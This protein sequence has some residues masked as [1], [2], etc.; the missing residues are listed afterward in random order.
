MSTAPAKIARPSGS[1]GDLFDSAPPPV[2]AAKRASG[3]ARR[4]YIEPGRTP[5]GI[6]HW[7][8][9]DHK[10]RR[11]VMSRWRRSVIATFLTEARPLR[12][13][14]ALADYSASRGYAYVGNPRLGVELGMTPKKVDE[15]ISALKSAGAIV[16]VW[17]Q[18]ANGDKERRIYPASAILENDPAPDGWVGARRSKKSP[19]CGGYRGAGSSPQAGDEG[20]GDYPLTRG[21]DL[22]PDQGGIESKKEK[23]ASS[24]PTSA[25]LS[26]LRNRN[27]GRSE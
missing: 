14:W 19:V 12:V 4:N 17:V 22:S 7:G 21:D 20:H 16:V 13:A 10:Q 26:A 23:K 5:L 25:R 2:G 15:A 24:H 27:V 11:E 9:D 6:L 8:R 18:S 1:S 3:A